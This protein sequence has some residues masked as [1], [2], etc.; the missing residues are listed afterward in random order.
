M[1]VILHN[2]SC[3]YG[4]RN[5]ISNLSFSF[6]EGEAVCIL[7]SNGVGKTTILKCFLGQMSL[8]AG[9][10]VVDNNKFLNELDFKERARLFS[11][12]PQAKS[13]SY[14]YKVRDVIMMG[15]AVY[16]KPFSLP[17]QYDLEIVECVMKKLD[18][19]SY[20]DRFY[21][22]LSGGEQQIVLLARAMVQQ[23][24]YILLDEPASNLDLSNQKKLMEIIKILVKEGVGIVMVSHIPEHAFSSCQNA[25]L[26]KK[27]RSYYYGKVH[28]VMT[29]KILSEVFDVNIEIV[30]FED[31]NR[32]KIRTCYLK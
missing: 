28:E 6:D 30:C 25:L 31:E 4:N 20:A 24:K 29:S 3:G 27:D 1:G 7:G 21:N 23:A 11:Y 16:I 18:I 5:V 13:F 32:K 17:S 19:F 26:L 15:R 9:E 12:V 10:I 2:I 22:N 8:T 14:Q